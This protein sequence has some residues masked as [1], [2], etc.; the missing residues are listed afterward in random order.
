[1][2]QG[3]KMWL[4]SS[5]GRFYMAGAPENQKGYVVKKKKDMDVMSG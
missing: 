5:G 1:M 4:E 2:H 3:R